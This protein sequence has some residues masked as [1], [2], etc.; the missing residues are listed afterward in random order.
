MPHLPSGA[1]FT[2]REWAK[3]GLLVLNGGSWEGKE[4]VKAESLA[5]CFKPAPANPNYGMT[6]WKSKPTDPIPDLVMAAGKG[7]QKLFMIPSKKL[8]IVQFADAEQ[9]YREE[10]FLSLA[11]GDTKVAGTGVASDADAGIE[12][13]MAKARV[14]QNFTLLD[15]DGDGR[16]SREEAGEA[17]DRIFPADTNQDGFLTLEEATALA[18]KIARFRQQRNPA[19][20]K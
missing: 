4:I 16:V 6:F 8:L 17:A 9:R 10:K 14:E 19:R 18:D 7:K 13:G 11:L 1:F 15:K 2:A 3:F 5:E 12:S 20:K